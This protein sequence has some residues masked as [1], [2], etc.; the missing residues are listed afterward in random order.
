MNP[1]SQ[2]RSAAYLLTL[3]AILSSFTC[4]NS[5]A[6]I[7]DEPSTGDANVDVVEIAPEKVSVEGVVDDSK[8]A[9]R[10]KDIFE[11]TGWFKDVDVTSKNGF[12]TIEGLADSNAH[13][14]WASDIATR[15][16]DVIGIRNNLEVD[17]T[18]KFADSMVVVGKSLDK[19]YREL[20]VRIPF[21]IAGLILLCITWLV[22][23]LIHFG[24]DRLLN[25]RKGLRSSLK[26]LIKQL[27]SITV[28]LLGFLL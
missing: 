6:Q 16:T 22:S 20:L 18:V 5:Q 3:A 13:S 26:D 14:D 7:S 8:I 23:K 21:L 25:S 1:I 2:F 10:L 4:Q 19:Q 17:S 11:S 28:W 12:V 9:K 15:T 24:L 27:S